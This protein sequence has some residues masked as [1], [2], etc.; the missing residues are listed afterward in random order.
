MDHI[1]ANA[2]WIAIKNAPANAE[3]EAKALGVSLGSIVS[4]S[5]D[6]GGYYPPM[7]YASKAIGGVAMAESARD[8]VSLPEGENLIK[9]RVT[10][11][12]IIK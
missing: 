11:T 12:Y 2:T 10:I 6:N 7:M 3:E 5:E 8:Q 9:S 1:K 4:F